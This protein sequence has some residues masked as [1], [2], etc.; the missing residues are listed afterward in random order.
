MSYNS[1]ND[2]FNIKIGTGIEY[3]EDK[4]QFYFGTSINNIIKALPKESNIHMHFDKKDGESDLRVTVPSLGL[5]FHFNDISQE[6]WAIEF[7]DFSLVNLRLNNRDLQNRGM[8]YN[9]T[10]ASIT[11]NPELLLTPDYVNEDTYATAFLMS[12]GLV[13]SFRVEQ[14][15]P[16]I[17]SF[18]Q[19]K[20][21]QWKAQSLYLYSNRTPLVSPVETL[22][23]FDNFFSYN[24]SYE[25]RKIQALYSGTKPSITFPNFMGKPSLSIGSLAQEVTSS[26]GPPLAVHYRVRLDD[27]TERN[28]YYYNYFHYGI[29]ILFDGFSHRAKLFIFHFNNPSTGRYFGCY[30]KANLELYIPFKDPHG[31]LTITD[32]HTWGNISQVFNSW[33]PQDARRLENGGIHPVNTF[34]RTYPGLSLETSHNGSFVN[35][36]LFSPPA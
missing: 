4:K 20:R 12:K 15:F 6:L 22:S 25:E 18:D 36:S 16:D 10:Y 19:S 28:D 3:G 35:I 27:P 32:S 2:S 24:A 17:A 9:Y 14:T 13:F 7:F 21:E 34:S 11:S 30:Q 23:R 1:R 26:I 8:G 29:D 33:V 31:P 5:C